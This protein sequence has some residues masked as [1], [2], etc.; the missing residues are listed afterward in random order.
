M[1][2]TVRY[3]ARQFLGGPD[4]GRW[5]VYDND[6]ASWP[7]LLPGVPAIAPSYATEEQA[8]QVASDVAA[9]RHG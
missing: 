1:N 2:W 7:T 4:R 8:A 5:G 9:R 3:V 6:H